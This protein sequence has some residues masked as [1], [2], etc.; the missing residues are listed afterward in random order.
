M[1][2]NIIFG[3]GTLSTLNIKKSSKFLTQSAS[4]SLLYKNLVIGSSGSLS[5]ISS[6]FTNLNIPRYRQRYVAVKY[7]KKKLEGIFENIDEQNLPMKF[8]QYDLDKIHPLKDCYSCKWGL[9]AVLG[10]CNLKNN[11][12][13]FNVQKG[14][15]SKVFIEACSFSELS[16]IKGLSSS[17]V[18]DHLV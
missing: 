14:R 17:F 11:Y 16:K 12:K 4:G 13:K 3:S 9:R 10:K 15:S 1:K 6:L 5:S 18:D 2:N 8:Y 7:D